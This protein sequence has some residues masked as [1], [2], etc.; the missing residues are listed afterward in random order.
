METITEQAAGNPD[1]RA[2]GYRLA[3]GIGMPEDG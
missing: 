3:W 1:H 2:G